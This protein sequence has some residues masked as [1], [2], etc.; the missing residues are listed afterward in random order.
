MHNNFAVL[1]EDM[2]VPELA[3]RHYREALRIRP[4]Y[5]EA[6]YNLALLLENQ[7]A[8]EQAS[9]HYSEALRIRPSYAEA[10]NN[11]AILLQDQG[12]CSGAAL[13]YQKA[14]ALRPD[15][16]QTHY[17]YGLL[18]RTAGDESGA[19]EHL[20][21]ARELAPVD[22][23][24]VVHSDAAVDA[25]GLTARELE[26]LGLIAIGRTNRDIAEALVITLSTVAHHVTSILSK[27][28]AANR[29]EAAAFANSRR[30]FDGHRP[31]LPRSPR[32]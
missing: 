11:L 32:E 31:D 14:M 8:N 20:R 4:D 10:H 28:G 25:A 18:L 17:N 27:T 7:D 22:W 16:P 24:A 1:Q 12:D 9:H 3:E 23:A 5:A 26:V 30:L 6:H 21:L 19:E 13:H 29:T 15:D 2:G